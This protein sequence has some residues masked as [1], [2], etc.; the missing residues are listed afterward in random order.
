MQQDGWWWAP[1]LDQQRPIRRQ[2]LKEMLKA[3]WA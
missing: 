3:R 2:V 1:P